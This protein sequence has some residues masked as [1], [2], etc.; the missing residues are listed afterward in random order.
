MTCLEYLWWMHPTFSCNVLCGCVRLPSCFCAAHN[1]IW[2]IFQ[3]KHHQIKIRLPTFLFHLNINLNLT[4]V[5]LSIT[6][7]TSYF[8]LLPWSKSLHKKTK[9]W[10]PWVGW[11][12]RNCP[13]TLKKH[14]KTFMLSML[15]NTC[16]STNTA[17]ESKSRRRD[18]KGPY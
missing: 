13:T 11:T 5:N 8:P 4:V 9:Q 10:R 7:I 16:M 18:A 15:W 17:T 2:C 3:G 1:S 12:G 6:H 14:A